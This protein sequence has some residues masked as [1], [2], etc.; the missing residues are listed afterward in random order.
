MMHRVPSP[1]ASFHVF[2]KPDSGF[3]PNKWGCQLPSRKALTNMDKN[4]YSRGIKIKE[5]FLGKEFMNKWWLIITLRR[6]VK[7]I[8]INPADFFPKARHCQWTHFT[9]RL[10]CY[11]LITFHEQ[12]MHSLS[13]IVKT[14]YKCLY[15]SDVIQT[16]ND[17]RARQYSCPK[18]VGTW[19]VEFRAKVLDQSKSSDS[20]CILL[21]VFIGQE[22]TWIEPLI[23]MG[24]IIIVKLKA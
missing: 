8:Q 19:V 7:S 20:T 15:T 11:K 24:I 16:T 3:N 6:S 1:A 21:N 23:F 18:S 10:R 12:Y 13:M 9:H 2:A 5:Y 14:L 17:W 4:I 22:L